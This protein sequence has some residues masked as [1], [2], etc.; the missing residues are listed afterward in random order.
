MSS[1]LEDVVPPLL[2]RA[3]GGLRR[4]FEGPK[5]DPYD[6]SGSHLFD[7]DNALFLDHAPRARLYGEYG[8]GASTVWMDRETGARI[9]AVDTAETWVED[10]RA[11][12]RRKE[13]D[14][15]WIDVGP[16]G[17]WGMPQTYAYRH[18]FRSYVEAL[19]EDTETPDFVLVDGRFRV[20]SFL[21]TL[22]RADP[23]TAVIFDDYVD[24]APFHVVE[25]FLAPEQRTSRQALFVVPRTVDH[26]TVEAT[27]DAF[28]MVR[29]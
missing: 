14:L 6:S 28:L 5:P 15:R 20:A 9:R 3:A 19:W 10:T 27:R 13:H 29:D 22:L 18:A 4:Q 8:M 21:T 16:V 17:G 24:R 23:G 7:G 11:R 2:Y 25:E 26:A 1:L 12:M